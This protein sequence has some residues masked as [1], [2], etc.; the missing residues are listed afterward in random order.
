MLAKPV[1]VIANFDKEG[2]MHPIKIKLEEDDEI[3]VIKVARVV[4]RDCEKLVGNPMWKL[5]CVSL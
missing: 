5:T 1:E 4:K 3:N 2:I